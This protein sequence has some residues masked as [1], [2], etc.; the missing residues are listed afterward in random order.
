VNELKYSCLRLGYSTNELKM[1]IKFA[2]DYSAKFDSYYDKYCEPVFNGTYTLNQPQN[3]PGQAT[4]T[5]A[6]GTAPTPASIKILAKPGTTFCRIVAYDPKYGNSGCRRHIY[7]TKKQNG[8]YR[9]SIGGATVT[10]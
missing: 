1:L 7:L 4:K 2:K 8:S 10:S 6:N 5:P 9:V 3:S